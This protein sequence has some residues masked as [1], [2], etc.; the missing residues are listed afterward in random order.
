WGVM[1]MKAVISECGTYRY[2]LERT[3]GEGSKTVVW[4]MVNPSTA[5]HQQDD[6]TI[7]RLIGFTRRLGGGRLV[8][9]NKFAFRATDVA[10]LE[11]AVDPAG[12][13]NESH[14]VAAMK[15]ADL[16]VVGW[17][18]LDKLPLS[19]RNAYDSVCKIAADI[20]MPLTCLAI[21]KDGSPRHPLFVSS[22][23]ELL[24]WPAPTE[25]RP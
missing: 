11:D 17:G 19:L 1:G 7:R 2:R 22:D 12:P 14:I 18:K 5:D 15:E 21:N 10:E 9:V 4:I 3:V 8:V 20:D 16:C 25:G 13:D 24:P 6:A 23:A